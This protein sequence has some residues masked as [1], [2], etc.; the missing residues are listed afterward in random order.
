M[1]TSMIISFSAKH[2]I[3]LVGHAPLF[4]LT[5]ANH[6][7]QTPCVRS[8]TTFLVFVQMAITK[9]ELIYCVLH[10][11]ELAKIA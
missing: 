7:I 11:I 9:V 3:R 2:V 1:G 10:A 4:R 6:A 8:W 5:H